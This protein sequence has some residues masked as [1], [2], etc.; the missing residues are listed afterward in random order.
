LVG[1][2]S[3]LLPAPLLQPTSET[4]R[5]ATAIVLMIADR[6]RDVRREC[7]T[8]LLSAVSGDGLS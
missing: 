5:P 4:R 6:D 2:Q 1:T 8:E 3:E 7:G